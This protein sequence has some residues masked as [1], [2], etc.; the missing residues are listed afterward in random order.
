[1]HHIA[2]NFSTNRHFHQVVVHIAIHTRFLVQLDPFGY[3][4]VTI[5]C[6]V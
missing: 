4:Y 5:Y 1:M 2:I 6:T 3:M